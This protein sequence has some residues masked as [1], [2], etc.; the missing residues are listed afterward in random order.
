MATLINSGI[1]F[2]TFFA[3]YSGSEWYILH[4]INV[5]LI[6]VPNR[7]TNGIGNKLAYGLPF[8]KTLGGDIDNVDKMVT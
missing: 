8:D 3:M 7:S 1:M 5:I 2:C 4:V 6:C